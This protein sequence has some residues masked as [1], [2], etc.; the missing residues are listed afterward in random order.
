MFKAVE[1]LWADSTKDWKL[2]RKAKERTLSL[3]SGGKSS[4]FHPLYHWGWDAPSS[5]PLSHAGQ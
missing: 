4:L 5:K 2:V 1:G 3:Y